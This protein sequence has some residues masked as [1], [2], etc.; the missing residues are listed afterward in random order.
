MKAAGVLFNHLLFVRN[1]AE[2]RGMQL[3][4]NY[5]PPTTI[6]GAARYDPACHHASLMAN[7]PVGA[8]RRTS[9]KARKPAM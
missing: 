1:G 8:L 5:A 7:P 6:V 2:P 3:H 4:K 9:L